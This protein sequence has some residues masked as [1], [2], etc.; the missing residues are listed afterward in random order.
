M[1]LIRDRAEISGVTLR[2][3]LTSIFAER[4]THRLP[5]R[6][7]EPPGD[8]KP[9]FERLAEEVGREADLTTG[10]RQ[11]AA[12]VNPVLEGANPGRWSPLEAAWMADE[13]AR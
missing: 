3:A 2:A 12:F 5:D 10:Y 1:L 8:W 6:L 11:V 4:K 13:E 9:A 7:P